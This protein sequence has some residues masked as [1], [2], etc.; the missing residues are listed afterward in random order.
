M[1]DRESFPLA[2]FG[3][4]PASRRESAGWLLTVRSEPRL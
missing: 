3:F 1:S 4:L 2:R